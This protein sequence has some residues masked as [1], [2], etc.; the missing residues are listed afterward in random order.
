MQETNAKTTR[1]TTNNQQTNQKEFK[2]TNNIVFSTEFHFVAWI[3][4]S[5]SRFTL[6]YADN[7]SEAY[8][9]LEKEIIVEVQM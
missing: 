4:I 8:L 5:N 2:S 3:T 1:T 9:A 6:A 7:R